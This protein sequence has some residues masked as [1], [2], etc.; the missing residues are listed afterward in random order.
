[1]R[2]VVVTDALSIGRYHADIELNRGYKD[3]VDEEEVIFGCCPTR[4]ERSSL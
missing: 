2:E 4:K 1:M 3:I